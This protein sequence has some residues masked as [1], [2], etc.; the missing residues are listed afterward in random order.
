MDTLAMNV[1]N[2]LTA[3]HSAAVHNEKKVK[4][5]KI[6]ILALT[7]ELARMT[8]HIAATGAR[9]KCPSDL[10][11]ELKEVK[12]EFE[13]FKEEVA[14]ECGLNEDLE[15][16]DVGQLLE[17]KQDDLDE[18]GERNTD[19]SKFAMDVHNLLFGTKFDDPDIV[20]SFD[21]QAIKRK[22]G[23]QTDGDLKD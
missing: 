5:L 6:D 14:E 17:E 16:S 7:E 13:K 2:S 22:I 11:K 19:L 3:L 8:A 18:M 4:E 15:A 10:V 20:Q 21:F 9:N 1:H 12:A 23:L